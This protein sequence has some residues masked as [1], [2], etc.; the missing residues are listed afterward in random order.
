MRGTLRR[1]QQAAGLGV[2]C[3]PHRRYR[4]GEDPTQRR[5]ARAQRTRALRRAHAMSRQR[6]ALERRRYQTASIAIATALPPPR[7]SDA[8]PRFALRHFRPWA[9]APSTRAPLAPIG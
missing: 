4:A 5:G 6:D 7:Q 3:K 9:S 2:R 8:M 1:A